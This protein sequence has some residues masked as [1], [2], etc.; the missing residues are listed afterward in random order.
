[1]NHSALTLRP[2]ARSVLIALALVP[3]LSQADTVEEESAVSEA[4]SQQSIERIQVSG[5]LMSSAAIT[6]AERREQSQVADLMDA[7]MIGRIGDS[8]VG[9]ALK[10]ITGLT[11]VDNKFIYVRGL[12]ERYSST[13]LNGAI[14][15]TQ[16]RLATLCH[17]TCPNRHYR[18]LGRTKKVTR[19][20]N[21]PRLVAVV[22]IS[23][24]LRFT[25]LRA[26]VRNCKLATGDK[27]H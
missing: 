13:L 1:M 26:R 11:L 5:R 3:M 7:E 6:A 15:P 14:V 12:G 18:Q 22:S 19:L 2:A 16:T 8:N 23:G 25:P 9:D 27:H 17:W 10:R 4:L 20:T 24:P 21:Q